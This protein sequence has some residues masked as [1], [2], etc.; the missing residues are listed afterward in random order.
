MTL[1]IQRV[2]SASVTIDGE[3]TA[4]IGKG[5]MILFGACNSDTDADFYAVTEKAVG[6]RIMEDENGKMNKSLADVGGSILAVPNFTLAADCRKGK[7]PS[8]INAMEPQSAKEY[9]LKFCK[10]CEAKGIPTQS[11]VFGA[12]MKVELINDGP[13]TI[14]LNSKDL[15]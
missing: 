6:L 4:E 3:K 9:F 11:G 10:E 14:I 12:D 2:K 5:F 1:I 8:F 13:I 15:I 7:R